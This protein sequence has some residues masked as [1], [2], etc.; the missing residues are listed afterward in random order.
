MEFLNGDS[1]NLSLGEVGNIELG[2]RTSK[3]ILILRLAISLNSTLFI[4]CIAIIV[5]LY[6]LDIAIVHT[7]V[8]IQESYWSTSTFIKEESCGEVLE[9]SPE[10]QFHSLNF[11]CVSVK[12][13]NS[14]F[15]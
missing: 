11:I 7:L 12:V 4:S 14:A 6:M 15:D 5:H 3:H 2:A 8:L 13:L 10:I 1:R 9:P